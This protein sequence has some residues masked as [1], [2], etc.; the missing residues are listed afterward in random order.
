MNS[1]LGYTDNY[2]NQPHKSIV[3]KAGARVHDISTNNIVEI[4]PK[5]MTSLP[6]EFWVM[7]TVELFPDEDGIWNV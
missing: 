6:F 1:P 3:N 4:A 2:G 5:N 7:Q